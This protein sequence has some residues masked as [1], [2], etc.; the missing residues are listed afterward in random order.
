M[1][2]VYVI[3]GDAYLGGKAI[4]RLLEGVQDSAVER[5][6]AEADGSEV[7]G[8]A[9]TV[10]LFGRRLIIARIDA[11]TEGLES[12]ERYLGS[13]NTDNT[14]IL[15][16]ED[17]KKARRLM[18]IA[19][20][21]KALRRFNTPNESVLAG[22]ITEGLRAKGV[23]P[24]TGAIAELSK[25]CEGD[26]GR[27]SCEIKKYGASRSHLDEDLVRAETRD[28]QKHSIFELTDAVTRGEAGRAVKTY[29]ALLA[30]GEPPGRILYM[31][32]R[33]VRIAAKI[34]CS[35]NIAPLEAAKEAGVPKRAVDVIKKAR[36]SEK[37]ICAAHEALARTDKQIKTGKVNAT[38]AGEVA[39]G[40]VA[41]SLKGGQCPK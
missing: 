21:T 3:Q 5:I 38:I 33:Q 27:L 12:Y 1:E 15:V 6:E 39:A 23:E 16:I 11:A 37:G 13:P 18:E 36:I 40:M 7:V 34:I 8:K 22:W 31:I 10:G 4:S 30:E 2:P 35:G 28:G 20:Q 25:R 24:D 29:R 17:E 41:E 14:L 32:A 9:E 26:L 19:A